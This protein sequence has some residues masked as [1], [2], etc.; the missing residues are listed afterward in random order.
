MVGT[1]GRIGELHG[2]LMMARTRLVIDADIAEEDLQRDPIDVEIP[3]LG[4][5]KFPGVMP[6]SAVMRLTRWQEAGVST[7][8]VP[9][10]INLLGDLV[11]DTVLA[12]FA[13]AGFD[14]FT[15][16]NTKVLG[17]VISALIDEYAARD[18]QIA[19]AGPAP[20]PEA[21]PATP[22]PFSGVGPSSSPTSGAT[23][24]SP[25]PVT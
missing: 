21:G 13:A 2:H 23:T 24:S 9:Q 16:R 25:F 4:V 11:P 17:A 20:K 5:F 22:P 14:V 6:A 10:M 7:P 8:S 18:A 3:G 19:D 12:Q 15:A 1:V